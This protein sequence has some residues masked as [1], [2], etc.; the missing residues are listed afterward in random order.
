MQFN[1]IRN[2]TC[3]DGNAAGDLKRELTISSK[4]GWGSLYYTLPNRCHLSAVPQPTTMHLYLRALRRW[5]HML[6][7]WRHH[8]RSKMVLAAS[9][10]WNHGFLRM[11]CN[12]VELQLCVTTCGVG[13]C[14]ANCW[15]LVF[16]VGISKLS[17]NILSETPCPGRSNPMQDP[18]TAKLPSI[19]ENL[20]DQWNCGWA[21]V[22]QTISY[23]V[24]FSWKPSIVLT[25]QAWPYL[26][27]IVTWKRYSNKY[28]DSINRKKYT[29]CPTWHPVTT[30]S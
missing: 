14:Q 27:K 16:P 20:A 24:W 3:R 4:V 6:R 8:M 26:G 10:Q 22:C 9:D 23:Q 5:M 1:R 7:C 18:H 15:W 29:S 25:N 11:W 12:E 30:T 2:D 21:T 19:K 13:F 28:I 17:W